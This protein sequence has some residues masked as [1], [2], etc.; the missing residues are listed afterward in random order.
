MFKQKNLFKT[1][2]ISGLTVFLSV[3]IIY[4]IVRAGSLTPSGSDVDNGAPTSTSFTLTDIYNRL[5]TNATAIA[6]NH[7]FTAPVGTPTS[8]LYTLAQIYNKIPTINPANLLSST[9]YLGITGTITIRNLLA[10]TTAL[11]AGYYAATTLNAVDSDLAAGNIKSG[12]NVFGIAGSYGGG[13]YAFGSDDASYVL[14][15]AGAGA[16]TFNAANL[17]SSLIATGT[18]WGVGQVGTL[19]GH[20]WN[21]S[22]TAGGFPGGSQST[23]GVDDYNNGGSAPTDTYSK[24]WTRCTSGNSYCGTSDTFAAYKDDSTGLIWSAPCKGNGCTSYSTS[25]PSTYRWDNRGT[26]NYNATSS[27]SSTAS[28]LCS[29][30]LTLPP[31]SKSYHGVGWSLP[32]QKQL[33]MAYIDGAHGNLVPINIDRNYWSATTKS[34]D[35]TNAFY[36][37]LNSGV[38]NVVVKT[39]VVSIR[40]VRSN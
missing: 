3:L 25:S 6:G 40:C 18:V 2:A 27:A 8:T 29:Q 12:I 14:T 30:N 7:S 26:T 10:S 17:T 20:L 28:E 39:F 36:V 15:S 35:T 9:T 4:S 33:M 22:L 23:G 34:A 38:S 37:Y 31:N 1:I 13:G 32:H 24:G 21:G 16:G 19:L 11:S 5:N